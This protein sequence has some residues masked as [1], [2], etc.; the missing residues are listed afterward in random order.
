MKNDEKFRDLAADIAFDVLKDN[1]DGIYIMRFHPEKYDLDTISS[2]FRCIGD[3]LS[4]KKLVAMP[5]D[6][7]V[8][9]LPKEQ[10]KE[11]ARELLKYAEE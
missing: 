8:Q 5:Y 6:I 1:E 4:S 9:S 7:E 10:A 2:I 11:I 3:T